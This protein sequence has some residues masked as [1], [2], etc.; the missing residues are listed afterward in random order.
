MR[1]Y[2]PTSTSPAATARQQIEG[3]A[4][5][6]LTKPGSS[7]LSC[8]SSHD[9]AVVLLAAL[10]LAAAVFGPT[11]RAAE[12]AAAPRRGQAAP[13]GGAM[14]ALAQSPAAPR[15]LYAAAQASTVFASED[16]GAS[17]TA[18]GAAAIG[19]PY[20]FLL[21]DA[22]DPLTVY[23]VD[24]GGSM[25]TSHDGGQT[26]TMVDDGLPAVFALA[27]GGASPHPLY[28]ATEHG[29]YVSTDGAG[30]WRSL[31]FAGSFAAGIAVDPL[32]ATNLIAG[33]YPP[34]TGGPIT[35]WHSSDGGATWETTG[36]QVPSPS[37]ADGR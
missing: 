7:G 28:A 4:P 2:T 31:A 9:P 11:A 1:A 22:G 37:V 12:P 30:H 5:S 8:R 36:F 24:I 16:G 13:L 6:P 32:V 33:I 3:A 14:T 19:N 35:L 27:Q 20:S 10:L 23:A 34:N 29:L 25:W 26:W 15:T 18:R 17:W 21:A